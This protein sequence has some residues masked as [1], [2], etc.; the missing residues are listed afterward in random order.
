MQSWHRGGVLYL[1]CMFYVASVPGLPR[2]VLVSVSEDSMH[3]EWGRPGTEA[4]FYVRL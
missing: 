2:S 1:Q 3:T 4:M